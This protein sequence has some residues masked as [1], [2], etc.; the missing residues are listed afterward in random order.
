MENLRVGSRISVMFM[1]GWSLHWYP[2]TIT[3]IHPDV[4]RDEDGIVVFVDFRADDGD[5]RR[6]FR[7]FQNYY[8]RSDVESAWKLA[9]NNEAKHA[10]D[11]LRA[12]SRIQVMF[13][14][15]AGKLEWFGGKIV[16]VHLRRLQDKDGAIVVADIRFDD[17]EDK[18]GFKLFQD[19]YNRSDVASAW[20]L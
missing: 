2:A 19:Y 3:K 14:D 5:E 9:V 18:K 11:S 10:Q 7:L 12:G 1:K 15:N 16:R 17:G 13:R 4:G 6:R 8:D 20:R